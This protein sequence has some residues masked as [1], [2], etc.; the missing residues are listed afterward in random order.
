MDNSSP[1]IRSEVRESRGL[2][3]KIQLIVPGFRGYRDL[4]DLRI[5]DQL[6]RRQIS[7][8][9]DEALQKLQNLRVKM[10]N[11]NDFSRLTQVGSLIS[12]LQEFQ[13]EIA[14][15]Q[16]GYTGISPGIRVTEA[17]L[18][19]LYSYDLNFLTEVEDIK[20]L[21][22]SMEGGELSTSAEKL[23]NK[24]ESTRRAWQQRLDAIEEILLRPT[25]GK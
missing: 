17:R 8:V 18:S 1:D 23:Q 5:A 2:L 14:H 25:G 16:E 11:N 9:F 6:V 21:C 22:N 3:K 12:L 24:I 4:E 13:G 10:V 7:G 20:V 19:Q 15:A